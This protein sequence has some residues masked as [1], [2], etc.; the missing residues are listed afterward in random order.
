MSKVFFIFLF[1]SISDEGFIEITIDPSKV[2]EDDLFPASMFITEPAAADA[3][4][5]HSDSNS[6]PQSTR[7]SSNE[8]D[9]DD[10]EDEVE[11][12]LPSDRPQTPISVSDAEDDDDDVLKTSSAEEEDEDASEGNGAMGPARSG[13]HGN[14]GA[15]EASV[16]SA[17]MVAEVQGG[18]S[19]GPMQDEEESNFSKGVDSLVSDVVNLYVGVY[20]GVFVW[21]WVCVCG[22]G[23]VVCMCVW[24]GGCVCVCVC[25]SV[26]GWLLCV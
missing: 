15:E 6:S 2:P 4:P 13:P 8:G 14:R 21:V 26:C 7:L 18:R 12:I 25:K 17:R 24:G 23:G 5:P 3:D 11:E 20:V 19:V 16:P 1:I 9:N 22:V 10:E